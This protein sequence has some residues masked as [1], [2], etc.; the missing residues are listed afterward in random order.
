MLSSTFQYSPFTF[1]RH[2]MDTKPDIIISSEEH[3][4]FF[5]VR[6]QFSSMGFA[7]YFNQACM[8]PRV[9]LGVFFPFFNAR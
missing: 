9:S 5:L 1:K 7:S 2:A 6:L 3:C 8:R 4:K